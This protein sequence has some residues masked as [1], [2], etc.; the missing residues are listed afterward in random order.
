MNLLLYLFVF[1]MLNN[2]MF[3][4]PLLGMIVYIG[5]IAFFMSRS[6]SRMNAFR[7]NQQRYSQQGQS[8]QQNYQSTQSNDP[9]ILGAIDIEFSEEEVS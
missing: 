6:R 4:S 2:L 9:R 3:R 8:R 5:V 7:F 1:M